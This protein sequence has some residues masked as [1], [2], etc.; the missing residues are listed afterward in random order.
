LNQNIEG[1]LENR[2]NNKYYNNNN[3][4]NN[5]R[6]SSKIDHYSI[7]DQSYRGMYIDNFTKST[8]NDRL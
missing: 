1:S 5:N 3:Y 2:G 4:N 7:I 8:V 6:I